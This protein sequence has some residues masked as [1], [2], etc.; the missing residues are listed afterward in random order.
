MRGGV[1][2]SGRGV[3][4]RRRAGVRARVRRCG[5]GRARAVVR[6]GVHHHGEA[7][8]VEHELR[9]ARGEG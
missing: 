3:W 8:G 6:R 7:D 9:A 1:R 5:A 2:R 4:W